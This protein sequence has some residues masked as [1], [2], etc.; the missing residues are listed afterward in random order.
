MKLNKGPDMDVWGI[1]RPLSCLKKNATQSFYSKEKT[2]IILSLKMK[3][4][5]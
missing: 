5:N 1:S 2:G 3:M 4:K